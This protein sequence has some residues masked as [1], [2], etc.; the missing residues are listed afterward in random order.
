MRRKE[1]AVDDREA[2]ESFLRE[3][4]YGFLGTI[5]EAGEPRVLPL[6]FVWLNGCIYFHGSRAGEKMRSMAADSRVCFTV[7]KPYARIPSYWSDPEL[8]CPATVYFKSVLITGRAEDVTDPAEK[9]EALSA[10]M[11][12]LQPE[13]GYAPIDPADER[14]ARQLA[15]TA[16]V[17]I[18][19]DAVTAKFKFGQNMKGDKRQA[20]VDRLL[21][22]DGPLDRETAELMKRL[23]P[24][25]RGPQ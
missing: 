7:A 19:P 22:R 20:V 24:P 16:V 8:A 3:M 11:R 21:E 23:A 1:F 5:N 13:G 15:G 12:K 9:A 2:I 14:Y 18:T 25:D 17:K 4:D 10:F 6:N